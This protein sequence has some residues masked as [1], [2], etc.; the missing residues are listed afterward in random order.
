MKFAEKQW[1]VTLT[2][3]II[4][5]TLFGLLVYEVHPLLTPPF[6]ALAL[7]FILSPFRDQLIIRRVML[8]L[9]VILLIFLYQQAHTIMIPIITS[10]IL[11]YL[12]D[13]IV[14][15]FEAKKIKRERVI[16]WL[17]FFLVFIVSLALVFLVPLLI[18]EIR[19]FI[20]S[21]PQI[22]EFV[23]EKVNLIQSKLTEFGLLEEKFQLDDKILGKVQQIMET[24]FNASLKF[25]MA[26][27]S[28]ITQILNIILIPFLT[29]YF[30][31]DF[32][33]M[34][35]GI[36]KLVPIPQQNF[37]ADV[38]RKA[39]RII[40]L[41]LRG[42]LFVCTIIAVLTSFGLWVLGVQYAIL[43]GTMAGIANLIPYVGLTV[44]L[45]IAAIVSLFG[46][47]PW[48]DLIK[49]GGVFWGV[50]FLEGS[51]ISPR[52]V[53]KV[54]GLHPVVV[55]IALLLFASFFGFLG[56]LLAVPVTAVAKALLVEWHDRYIQSD[57][58]RGDD[59]LSPAP[60]KDRK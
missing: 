43:L 9:V 13:P 35:L 7:L 54:T 16:L 52:V 36:L 48:V 50:Q 33:R 49:V 31:A 1:L 28:T 51:F 42:Q 15:F 2:V 23:I 17:V 56:L 40:G 29:Y 39:D 22:K 37:I 5:S 46:P 44:T 18:N 45:I 4:F 27:S 34:R 6:L 55:M 53:G 47:N 11:A 19:D 8:L 10:L 30:L 57:F 59:T 26:A 14:D 58:Y 21:I 3:L 20:A 25:T 60:A 12:L 38:A 41:Y 24:V 32:D